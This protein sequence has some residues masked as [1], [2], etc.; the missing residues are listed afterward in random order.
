MHASTVVDSA[1]IDI[2]TVASIWSWC[3]TDIADTHVISKHVLASSVGFAEHRLKGTL[4]NI[5]TFGFFFIKRTSLWAHTFIASFGVEAGS[6]GTVSI[7]ATF[8]D[9]DAD[10]HE[11]RL[12][13]TFVADASEVSVSIVAFAISTESGADKALVNINTLFATFIGSETLVTFAF[14]AS[15]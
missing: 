7:K 11:F 1:L 12:F 10:F 14:E 3:I 4:I 15:V 9:V 5:N 6:S 2:D 13:V 8:I